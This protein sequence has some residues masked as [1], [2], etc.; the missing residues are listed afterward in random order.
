MREHL[1]V[2]SRTKRELDEKGVGK[3]MFMCLSG[4]HA[5]GWN[6]KDSDYDF[7][8]I[9]IADTNRLLGLDTPK[10]IFELRLPKEYPS[11]E[12]LDGKVFTLGGELEIV[13]FEL[14]K[15]LDLILRG[16]SNVLEWFNSEPIYTT[17]EYLKLKKLTEDNITKQVYN[18]Y[19]GMATYNY[20]KF[21]KQGRK[22]VK[23]YLYV[24]RALMAGITA[25]NTSRIEPNIKKLN[26]GFYL[27]EV[28]WLLN[29]KQSNEELPEDLK[30]SIESRIERLFPVLDD[31]YNR[32]SLPE[33]PDR[34]AFNKFLLRIRRKN[35]KGE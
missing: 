32:S 30:I 2:I 12:R 31:I 3:L 33:E 34:E 26:M 24:L 10:D 25:L 22:T 9:F 23:K 17:P 20:K 7:R 4:S 15:A 11:E 29:A 19:K 1:D 16:N 14:K 35:L 8:G 6:T 21:I 5:Y 27:N 18:A 13:L 28:D